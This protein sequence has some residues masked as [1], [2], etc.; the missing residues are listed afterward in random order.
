MPVEGVA[1]GRVARLA[2]GGGD[3][4]NAGGLVIG[5]AD[6]QLVGDDGGDRGGRGVSGDGDHVEAALALIAAGALGIG[7][8]LGWMA[9]G[10]PPKAELVVTTQ[11]VP[12]VTVTK[13]VS[14]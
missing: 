7:L 2:A 1:P 8:M 5:H 12:A 11:S 14:P 9:R 4:P 3:D 13:E 6:G 10:G